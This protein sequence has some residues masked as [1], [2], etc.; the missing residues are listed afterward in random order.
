MSETI[1]EEV[2]ALIDVDLTDD[3]E[4]MMKAVDF[5]MESVKGNICPL[6]TK[7]FGFEDDGD[8]PIRK[9]LRMA[10]PQRISMWYARPDLGPDAFAIL[11][12]QRDQ[13]VEYVPSEDGI[14]I[15]EDYDNPNMLHVTEALRRKY[16]S[17]YLRWVRRDNVRRRIDQRY[18][19]AEA[20]DQDLHEARYGSGGT[21]EYRSHELVLMVQPKATREK[22]LSRRQRERR[23]RAEK[24]PARIENKGNMMT[25]LERKNYDIL[26]TRNM[27]HTN[28][29]RI[30]RNAANEGRTIQVGRRRP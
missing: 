20:N 9:H 5:V 10:H 17:N 29:Y 25:D 28:A 23:E 14:E 13:E 12:R 22:I 19:L 8:Q 2:V 6:C 16:G 24:L 3:N 11:M 30:A 26:R 1:E 21:T 15:G 7:P 18:S 27:D 4:L